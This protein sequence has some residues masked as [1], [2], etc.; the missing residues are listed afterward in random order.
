MEGE[1]EQTSRQTEKSIQTAKTKHQHSRG[2]TKP[3]GVCLDFISKVQHQQLRNCS[4]LR[5]RVGK[6]REKESGTV[7]REVLKDE[8]DKREKDG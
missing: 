7:E 5:C 6:R 1:G 2:T 8:R 4:S 3:M